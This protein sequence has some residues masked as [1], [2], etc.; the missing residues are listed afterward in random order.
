VPRRILTRKPSRRAEQRRLSPR[1]QP[2]QARARKRVD[3]ILEVAGRLLAER[4]LEALSTAEIAARAGIPIGSVYQYFP[5][6]EAILVELAARKFQ[7]VDTAFAEAFGRGLERMAWRS[8]LEKTVDASVNAFRSDPAYVTVWRAMRSSPA[9]RS[10]AAA[11]DERFAVAL[12]A[13]PFVARLAPARRRVAVRTAIRIANTFLDW[14]LETQDPRQSAA[15]VREMKRSLVAYLAPDL[16][17]VERSLRK[18]Q[19]R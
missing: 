6:K 5:S 2:L 14:I 19:S 4:D 9:F 1:R 13:V 17:A 10:V 8:A 7:A 11:N 18:T 3:R 12:E 15:I 16:D